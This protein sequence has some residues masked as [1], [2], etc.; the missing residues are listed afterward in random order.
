MVTKSW[1]YFQSNSEILHSKI[2]QT[3]KLSKILTF[4]YSNLSQCNKN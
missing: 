4:R 1:N 2:P 3:Q